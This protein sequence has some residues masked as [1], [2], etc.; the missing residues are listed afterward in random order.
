MKTLLLISYFQKKFRRVLRIK[1]NRE[2]NQPLKIPCGGKNQ[3]PGIIFTPGIYIKKYYGPGWGGYD[4]Q[5]KNGF[6]GGNE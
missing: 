1:K 6:L 4:Y 5:G 3:L 2:K